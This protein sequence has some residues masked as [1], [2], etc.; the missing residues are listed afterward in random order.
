MGTLI[1]W[2]IIIHNKHF[3]FISDT[4]CIYS[5][6][7]RTQTFQAFLHGFPPPIFLGL[8][9]YIMAWQTIH[10]VTSFDIQECGISAVLVK[11]LGL[12]HNAETFHFKFMNRIPNS[13]PKQKVTITRV[14]T[15]N[16]H[17]TVISNYWFLWSSHNIRQFLINKDFSKKEEI[18]ATEGKF[19]SLKAFPHYHHIKILWL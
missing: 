4:Y 11:M 8:Q 3:I 7:F 17:V 6:N 15:V 12:Y 10:I 2:I 1:K 13:R 16:P 9:F 18:K 19:I 5:R 14:N